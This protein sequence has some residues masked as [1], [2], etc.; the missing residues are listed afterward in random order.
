MIHGVDHTEL[1]AAEFCPQIWN[2]PASLEWDRDL[3]AALTEFFQAAT[4]TDHAMVI[5]L[6]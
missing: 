3:F 1:A 6:D 2:S 4:S 5:R